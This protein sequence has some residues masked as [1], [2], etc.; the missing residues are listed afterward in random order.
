MSNLL[1]RRGQAGGD[2]I[3]SS[4]R[5]LYPEL[6][7]VATPIDVSAPMSQQSHHP[8]YLPSEA[9]EILQRHHHRAVPIPSATAV[10]PLS[11]PV[12]S[13]VFPSP[14]GG[15]HDISFSPDQK[16]QQPLFGRKSSKNTFL[17]DDDDEDADV[18]GDDDF[19]KVSA[20]SPPLTTRRGP[21]EGD[22]EDKRPS[23]LPASPPR[24]TDDLLSPTPP[25][26]TSSST[27]SPKTN[28]PPPPLEEERKPPPQPK[29][30]EDD[31]DED[32]KRAIEESKKES[33]VNVPSAASLSNHHPASAHYSSLSKEQ[34]ETMKEHARTLR[35]LLHQED[36]NIINHDLL[37]FQLKECQDDQLTV[38]RIIESGEEENDLLLLLDLNEFLLGAI[39]QARDFSRHVQKQQ[40]HQHAYSSIAF[41]TQQQQQEEEENARQHNPSASS[42]TTSVATETR[43]KDIF[44]LIYMLRTTQNNHNNIPQHLEAAVAL[45]KHT[46]GASRGNAS[47]LLLCEEIRSLG[48]FQSLLAVFRADKD[49]KLVRL[50]AAL[51]I[52]YMLPTFAVEMTPSL[53]LKI[54]EALHFCCE[55][56]RNCSPTPIVVLGEPLHVR[57]ILEATT[58]ALAS[59]WINYLEPLIKKKDNDYSEDSFLSS[60][61]LFSRTVSSTRRR[62]TT[63]HKHSENSPMECAQIAEMVHVASLIVIDLAGSQQ[64]DLLSRQSDNLVFLVRQSCLLDA[65]RPY[66]ARNGLFPVLVDWIHS[67]D[68]KRK[69]SATVALSSIA[70]SVD[71]YAAGWVHAQIVQ[72]K[73]LPKMMTLPTEYD[74]SHD[75]K[76]S[77]AEILATLTRIPHLR[78]KVIQS[79]PIPFLIDMVYQPDSQ[80]SLKTAYHASTAILE[81]CAYS[82]YRASVYSIG[83]NGDNAPPILNEVVIE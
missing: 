3:S 42:T 68:E 67:V 45:M 39:S 78:S 74:L 12:S 40:H 31:M 23:S 36:P 58:I 38:T 75:V 57:D 37:N 16:Q 79:D 5:S 24:T 77:L 56:G 62:V 72:D 9:R 52:A 33:T 30:E 61:T 69:L 43:E 17:E 22:A 82:I 15:D 73:I 29:Q 59:F 6:P 11:F 80:E 7:V 47:S 1:L 76:R 8:R 46:R 4:S 63:R 32:L 2:R 19:R 65:V 71:P 83:D 49:E 64:P 81:L 26:A 35:G 48:G 14:Q 21:S 51:S 10:A 27:A 55:S 34:Q 54:L 53:G 41:D 13:I 20:T 50:V 60:A 66:M 70:C 44:G 25:A 28:H 18:D